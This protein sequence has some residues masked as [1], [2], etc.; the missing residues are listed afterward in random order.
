MSLNDPNSASATHA[1]SPN[2]RSEQIRLAKTPAEVTAAINP[3]TKRRLWITLSFPLALLFAV[4]FWWYVTS[5]ERLP[6][7]ESRISALENATLP[8]IRPKILFTADIDAFPPPPPG[9]AQ[10][11]HKVILQT[12]A[13]E[14]SR[15]VDG[16]YVQRRPKKERGWDIVYDDDKKNPT[17]L[18]MHIRRW[19]HANTSWPLEPY[20][21]ASESGLMTSGLEEGTLVIPIHP[22]QIGDR[23]LKQHYKIAIIN[24][25]LGLYPPDP[26]E[27]PLRALKYSPNIT[28][29]FV[30]LNEDASEGSYVRSW[31]I[32]SAIKEHFLPHIEPLAPIFN[33]T[34]ES[35]LLYQ[36]PLTFEPTYQSTDRADNERTI[37]A[38][39]EMAKNS[40][41]DVQAIAKEIADEQ[42]QKAWLIDEEQM[43]VFVN[44][45]RWSLDSGSTNNP[46]LRFLLYVPAAKHRPMR[47]ASPNSAQSF[48][49]PQFGGVALLNPPSST[50]S[51][52]TYRL[53]LS[54]L[55][56]SFHLFTQHLYSLLALPP[57]PDKIHPSPP[58]TP[59]HAPSGLIQPITRWQVHQV[60]LARMKENSEEA[61]KTL[62]GIVRLVEKIKEMKVGEGVRG[63]VIGAV[64]RLEQ[65]SSNQSALEMFVL[66]RDAVN[67]ANQAFFDHSMMG[68]LYFPDEHKF[69][70]YTPLFA[71]I[72]VPII[73]GLIKELLAERKRRAAK[74]QPS[75]VPTDVLTEQVEVTG[76]VAKKIE[77]EAEK[78][79]VADTVLL[80][81]SGG[82]VESES[83]AVEG[84]S[85]R[86]R[87]KR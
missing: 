85:L 52:Q 39:V 61:R 41:E 27:I 13:E 56:P 82:S 76:P 79:P 81:T 29:S 51:S 86:S 30:L 42:V 45:E 48:L 71:P 68:L 21:Q 84:R 87:S 28:L 83:T 54:A 47:L 80:E 62:V 65:L 58:P 53:P 50:P 32:E 24:S 78:V 19:E 16:I 46:V 8:S 14:V 73:L 15:G 11:E 2:D 23:F 12:L 26:P 57:I 75:K 72:A 40:E 25:L 31:D 7:P 20:V 77:V 34:I 69:A 60:L 9:R 17:P 66:T 37:E 1:S 5:I 44:S 59:L 10:F 64:E 35:Q 49:L 33:F 38:T 3:S 36:A 63:K 67:L 74:R 18:R 4:P 6:L 43:K 55:T 70:V 22:S